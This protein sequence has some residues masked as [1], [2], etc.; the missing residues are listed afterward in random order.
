MNFDELLYF[1][2]M[3]EQQQLYKAVAEN[4]KAITEPS[5]PPITPKED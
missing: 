4:Q 3:E 1:V 5:C 2:F